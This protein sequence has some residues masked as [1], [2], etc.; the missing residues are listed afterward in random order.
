MP[1]LD[2]QLATTSLAYKRG[3]SPSSFSPHYHHPN[4]SLS[5]PSFSRF[6]LCCCQPEPPCYSPGAAVAGGASPEFAAALPQPLVASPRPI[7]ATHRCPRPS[8]AKEREEEETGLLKPLP[9]RAQ[10]LFFLPTRASLSL[11]FHRH[12]RVTSLASHRSENPTTQI[13]AVAAV[14][15][16][17]S[18]SRRLSRSP[19]VTS[20]R[21]AVVF[22]V[23]SPP[24]HDAKPSR[25]H[26]VHP[27]IPP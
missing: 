10:R 11:A 12:H 18:M 3:S 17:S 20:C 24:V 6:A 16:A 14:G 27:G 19:R 26:L 21:V 22:T 5:P 23:E 13:P 9:S 7:A 25:R 1:R 8:R 15:R 2:R 4:P